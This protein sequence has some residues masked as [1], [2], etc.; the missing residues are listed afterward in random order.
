MKNMYGI[1][2]IRVKSFE[3]DKDDFNEV[4]NFLKEYD[5]DIIDMQIIPLFYGKS[6]CVIVYKGKE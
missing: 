5:G 2:N 4:N 6:R 1:T 3:V